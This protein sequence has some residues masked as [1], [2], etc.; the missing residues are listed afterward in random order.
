MNNLSINTDP[1]LYSKLGIGIA[2]FFGAPLA[3][4]VLIRHNFIQLGERKNGNIALAL[5]VFATIVIFS[6]IFLIGEN[7]MEKVPSQLVP[8]IYTAIIVGLVTTFQ[9]KQLELYKEGG[10]T[11]ISNWKATGIGA[12]CMIPLLGVILGYA[13]LDPTTR[14]YD[15]AMMLF[16]AN[17]DKAINIYTQMSYKTEFEILGEI[18]NTTLPA[19]KA[20]IELLDNLSRDLALPRE[21][22]EQNQL[23]REYCNLRIEELMLIKR[24]IMLETSMYNGRIDSINTLIEGV[25]GRL[26]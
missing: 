6:A 20:N 12:L 5:G 13:F 8:T 18:N 19:W 9:G 10:N 15:E 14:E 24:N 3:A 23:L 11:F 4:G 21:F 26:E 1:K 7:I 17:E 16:S 2:T 22:K 25:L